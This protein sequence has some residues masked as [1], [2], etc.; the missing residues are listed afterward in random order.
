MCR[1][2]YHWYVRTLTGTGGACYTTS[3]FL[4]YSNNSYHPFYSCRVLVHCDCSLLKLL[5]IWHEA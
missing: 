2:P 5:G 4:I 1:R 3:F